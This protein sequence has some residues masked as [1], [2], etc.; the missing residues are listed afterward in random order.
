MRSTLLFIQ[1]SI[2]FFLILI[3]N[4]SSIL[5]L[6]SVLPPSRQ[7]VSIRGCAGAVR[8]PVEAN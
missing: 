5:R 7:V 3:W 2:S 1:L 6:A 8:W 4:Q